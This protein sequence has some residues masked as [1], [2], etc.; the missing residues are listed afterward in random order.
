MSLVTALGQTVKTAK[1]G[2]FVS[3]MLAVSILL[4]VF[5]CVCVCVCLC[6]C[7]CVCVCVRVRARAFINIGPL[8][9]VSFSVYLS[10]SWSER[11]A[12]CLFLLNRT[13]C[14]W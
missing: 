8:I 3:P 2:L 14:R 7:V 6:V 13:E 10:M 11:V 1:Q 4:C 12:N 9:S 5:V